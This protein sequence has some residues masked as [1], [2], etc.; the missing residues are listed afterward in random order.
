MASDP[1]S[2]FR[3]SLKRDSNRI[4]NNGPV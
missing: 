1:V 2:G 4:E 3:S